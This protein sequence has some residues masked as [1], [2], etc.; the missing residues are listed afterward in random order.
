MTEEEKI[1]W[2]ALKNRHTSELKFR[3]Q[4]NIGPYI[5]DFLCKEHSAIIEVDGPIHYQQEQKEHDISRDIYLRDRGFS[6]LRIRN[7]DVHLCLPAV[8]AHI[9]H[10]I[11][12]I[13][14]K[15]KNIHEPS[16]TK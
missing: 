1:L 15:Q 9:R 11:E 4:V 16:P 14:Q 7:E 13:K 10:F 3:R 12:S 2:N 8:I 5:V 6:I